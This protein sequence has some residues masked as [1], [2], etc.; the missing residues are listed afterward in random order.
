MSVTVKIAGECQECRAWLKFKIMQNR[1]KNTVLLKPF[2]LFPT[3]TVCLL[4]R[5]LGYLGIFAS[6]NWILLCV[7]LRWGSGHILA[8]AFGGFNEAVQACTEPESQK[9]VSS[10]T[11]AIIGQSCRDYPIWRQLR[12]EVMNWERPDVGWRWTCVLFLVKCPKVETLKIPDVRA[13]S[14]FRY[15]RSNYFLLHIKSPLQMQ[16]L[17]SECLLWRLKRVNRENPTG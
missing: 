10:I 3:A 15:K 9:G 4:F 13:V 5:Y 1:N 2:R 8:A 11:P 16:S 12:C 6:F 14:S 17:S 7:W